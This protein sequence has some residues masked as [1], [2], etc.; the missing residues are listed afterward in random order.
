MKKNKIINKILSY[1]LLAI[2]LHLFVPA[3]ISADSTLPLPGGD[4]YSQGGIPVPPSDQNGLQILETLLFGAINYIKPLIGIVGIFFVTIAGYKMVV[5]G[6]DEDSV[7]SAK[8]TII[9]LIIAFMLISMSEDIARIFDMGGD[10]GTFLQNPQQILSRVRLFDR[11]VEIIVTFIKYLLASIGTLMLVISGARMIAQGS[12]EE[13]VTT[14]RK[15]ILYIAGALFLVYFG[16]IFISRVF[17]NVDKSVYNGIT[18]VHPQIDIKEGIEELVGI[19]NFS[20]NIIAPLIML[21]F[22]YG[23]FIYVFSRGSEDQTEKA[24]RIMIS[25]GVG[26]VMVYSAFA[27]VSTVLAGRL[28]NVN[29]LIL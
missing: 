2:A 18:G 24:K 9:Y 11:Q 15:K 27:I 22:V 17:Y 8:Q 25:A 23:G 12:N 4:I 16:D 13:E 10:R 19:I 5:K 7:T 28:D 3:I 21:G 1:F 6:G 14:E 26:L 20:M 29:A